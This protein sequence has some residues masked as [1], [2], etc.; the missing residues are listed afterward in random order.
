MGGWERVKED[1]RGKEEQNITRRS[2]TFGQG[3][4]AD[5]RLTEL[6]GT[7][8]PADMPTQTRVGDSISDKNKQKHG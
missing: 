3:G 4:G 8:D 7:A 1:R 2:M 5:I 6:G